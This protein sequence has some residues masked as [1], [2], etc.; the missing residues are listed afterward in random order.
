MTFA[1]YGWGSSLPDNSAPRPKPERVEARARF[2]RPTGSV[3][4]VHGVGHSAIELAE[5]S[6]AYRRFLPRDAE[7]MLDEPRRDPECTECG[8]G[9][10]GRI[11]LGSAARLPT[12]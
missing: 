11:G 5:T 1:R 12:R 9:P 3:F 2:R 10:R 7:F 6:N 4:Q 8:S